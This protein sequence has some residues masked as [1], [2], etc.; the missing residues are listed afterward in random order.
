M[1]MAFLSMVFCS[2]FFLKLSSV[3]KGAY[4]L[5]KWIVIPEAK[6]D[7]D[8]RK[9]LDLLVWDGNMRWFSFELLRQGTLNTMKE[10]YERAKWYAGAHN[11]HVYMMNVVMVDQEEVEF[12]GEERGPITVYNVVFSDD[13]MARL[14]G[15][16]YGDAGLEDRFLKLKNVPSRASWMYAFQ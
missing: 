13:Q 14:I 8:R 1:L 3:L 6:C 2:S 5:L 12:H 11:G 9:W 10:H 15:G 16:Y 4:P 7:E